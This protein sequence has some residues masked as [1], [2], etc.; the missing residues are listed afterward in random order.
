MKLIITLFIQILVFNS[1]FSQTNT[2]L[3][4]WGLFDGE[5]NIAVNPTNPNNIIA[6]WMQL[7]VNLKVGVAVRTSTD[8]GNNWGSTYIIPNIAPQF[9]MADP[10]VVFSRTGTAY[11]CYIDYGGEGSD[12]GVVAIIKSTNSGI[13][14]S[15]PLIVRGLKET[16]DFALDRPWI[17][18]DNSSGSR[19]GYLYVSS[20][21]PS[22]APLPHAQHLKYSSNGGNSLSN[23]IIVSNSTYPGFHGSMGIMNVSMDGALHIVYT[24]LQGFTPYFA[25]ARTTNLGQSFTRNYPSMFYSVVDTLYQVSYSLTS[26]P[27]NPQNINMFFTGKIGSDPDIY[28][29]RSTNGGNNWGSPLRINNDIPNNG[30][31]QDMSWSF[32]TNN[33]LGV[34]WRDRRNGTPGSLSNFDIYYSV[35]TNGGLSFGN[36]IKVTSQS[37]PFNTNGVRGND[38]L[39]FTIG[40]D[41][42]VHMT[43]ADYRLGGIN[44]EIFY[45]KSDVNAIQQISNVIPEKFSIS[46]NYPNPFNPETKIRFSV[47]K[48]D[49]KD[50]DRLVKMIIYDMIGREVSAL[51]NEELEP[52]SYEVNWNASAIPSGIYICKIS[53]G[54]FTDQIKMSLIK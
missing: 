38:F 16:S 6:A 27:Q 42:K 48:S 44:W 10:C 9:T 25:Y 37:S 30:I 8:G 15:S 24:S 21:P 12:T 22:W 49:G 28:F 3:S 13:N 5:Q 4:N 18:I 2:N 29:I 7:K 47:P 51:V 31:G 40:N 26:D 39:G 50:R 41:S 23:D 46:Q 17:V 33:L 11:V 1:I 34:G 19:D 43:W 14:W 53:A 54:S 35:S 52:G 36:N 32:Q 20:M 45:N